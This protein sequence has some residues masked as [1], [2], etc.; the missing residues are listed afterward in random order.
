ME[1][2]NVIEDVPE[3]PAEKVSEESFDG[4]YADA[5]KLIAE[6]K[7]DE[8]QA[9]LKDVKE[10]TGEWHYVQAKLYIKKNWTNEARKELKRAVKAE[11]DNEKYLEA[12][13]ELELN[14]KNMHSVPSSDNEGKAICALACAECSCEVCAQGI[15]DGIC[16]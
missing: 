6:G 14:A 2:D 11:P 7:L 15:C 3:E 9:F 8:A 5:E 12:L 13:E 10:K 4:P 16:G 1:E